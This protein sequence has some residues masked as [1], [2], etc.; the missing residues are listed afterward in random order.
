MSGGQK[1]RIDALR[2]AL[3]TRVVVADGAMGTMLQAQNPT[4]DDFQ[5]LEGCN[6]V[7]NLTRPDI[8]RS[9]HEEYFAAGVDCVETNT[10]GANHSALGEYDIPERVHE[11]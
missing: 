2:E 9:V 3:A 5:Q 4:L 11:L 8:V 10:F 7:L 1:Q 6:E